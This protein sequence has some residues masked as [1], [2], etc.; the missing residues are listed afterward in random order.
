MT[1]PP[2]P[3]PAQLRAILA[4]RELEALSRETRI[5]LAVHRL[6]RK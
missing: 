4:Q 1:K 3:T 6:L 5:A 2:Q